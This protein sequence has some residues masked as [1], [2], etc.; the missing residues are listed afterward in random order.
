MTNILIFI[1]MNQT[2][3]MD[4]FMSEGKVVLYE[5]LLWLVLFMLSFITG[6]KVIKLR[7]S[8]SQHMKDTPTVISSDNH[9]R[10]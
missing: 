1:I 2:V 4:R 9:M 6:R 3:I 5:V 10:K 8:M 7:R